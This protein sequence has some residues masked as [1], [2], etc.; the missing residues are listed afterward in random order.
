MQDS[1]VFDQFVVGRDEEDED[2]LEEYETAYPASDG[3]SICIENSE[4]EN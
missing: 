1:I 2:I 3:F 4:N